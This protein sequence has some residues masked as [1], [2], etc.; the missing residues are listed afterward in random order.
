MKN[1]EELT[2]NGDDFASLR[3]D[4]DCMI[5]KLLLMMQQNNSEE[6]TI[7]V[8]ATI[9]TVPACVDLGDGNVEE[10]FKPIITH[11]I[12]YTVP[13]KGS[14]SGMHDTGKKI[15]FNKDLQEFV[16]QYMQDSQ[17]SFYDEEHSGSAAPNYASTAASP[18]I[19]SGQITARSSDGST[20]YDL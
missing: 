12:E 16:L 18:G 15:V 20:V 2:L 17:C 9:S 5:Q 6:G 19:T 8:K 10:V 7:N 4:F 3:N 11:K 1:Y 14:K 13:V